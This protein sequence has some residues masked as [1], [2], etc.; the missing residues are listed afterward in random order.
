[1]LTRK[2]FLSG[3]L[4]ASAAI[5]SLAKDTSPTKALSRPSR[6]MPVLAYASFEVGAERPFSVLHIS[7]THL[8]AAYPS[9]D[10]RRVKASVTGTKLFGGEQEN[11]LRVSLAW[12]KKTTDYVLHT[13]DLI[14]FQTEANLDLVRKYYGTDVKMIGAIGNHERYME[15]TGEPPVN[16]PQYRAES[17]AALS[18]AYPFD[19]S[20]SSSV[21]HGV[22]FVTLANTDGT[23]T[24]EQ[25]AKFEAEV[26]KGLPIILCAHVPFFTD[27]IYRASERY[28]RDRGKKFRE[29]GVPAPRG[30]RK[31]QLEDSVTR[32]FVAA[33]KSQPLLKGVLVGH[34]HVA[35]ADR[36]S[37]TAMEYVSGANFNYSALEAMFI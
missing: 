16:S 6:S 24:A 35:V 4:M 9:E 29:A 31:R 3:V 27:G 32:D 33:L 15:K 8:T 18:Q 13:G 7:D 1:M 10:K 14:D 22:N 20:F 11:A 23:V 12:A 2:E 21:L 17:D 37:P 36:F 28:W 25:V 5:P 30:D 19:I 34:L 26:K